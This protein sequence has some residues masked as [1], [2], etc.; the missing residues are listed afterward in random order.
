MIW[1]DFSSTATKSRGIKWKR[2]VDYVSDSSE[3]AESI[4]SENDVMIDYYTK[5]L[6][7][8]RTHSDDENSNELGDD[9]ENDS[10]E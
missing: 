5:N 7:I 6:Q 4:D 8:S 9:N 2:V 1:V 10:S 3:G